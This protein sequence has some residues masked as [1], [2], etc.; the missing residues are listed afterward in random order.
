[1]CRVGYALNPKKLRKS[2]V[3]KTLASSNP[4][5]D[6]P[7]KKVVGEWRGGGLSDILDNL[8][9]DTV[10][11]SIWDH[12]VP[13]HLQPEFDVIIHK[14]T[15]DI[16]RK[17]SSDKMKALENY[18]RMHPNTAIVDPIDSVRKVI[19]RSRTCQHLR[20]VETSMGRS[21]PFRQPKYV[22]FEG[23]TGS[24]SSSD[25][26]K[27]IA[28]H[29]LEFPIICKPVE[30]CGTA[31]SHHMVRVRILFNLLPLICYFRW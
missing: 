10:H 18:L 20:A 26:L 14:L 22:V 5:P 27:L 31:I 19:S 3:D 21:C 15:E 23:A 25:T 9:N 30:A 7:V 12:E 16:D 29:G 8:E 24:L 11:F 4:L 28:Q 2:S 17:E 1:M 13:D 6:S